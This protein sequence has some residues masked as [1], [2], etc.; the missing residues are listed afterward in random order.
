[1]ATRRSKTPSSVIPKSTGKR[2]E[3]VLHEIECICGE[4]MPVFSLIEKQGRTSE[5]VLGESEAEPRAV[6]GEYQ[7]SVEEWF[8]TGKNITKT[9]LKKL[10][11]VEDKFLDTVVQCSNC[12][13]YH[14]VIEVCESQVSKRLPRGKKLWWFDESEMPEP[15]EQAMDAYDVHPAKKAYLSW[16]IQNGHFER[17][18]NLFTE[19]T[20]DGTIRG[21]RISFTP[22][23]R[24]RITPFKGWSVAIEELDD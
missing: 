16:C 23:G 21:R 24:A 5:Y 7:M 15:L 9:A 19:V 11:P 2:L 4:V 8:N 17:E 14:H 20:E 18:V 13:A 3:P 1:M 12:S 10:K 6:S 22:E